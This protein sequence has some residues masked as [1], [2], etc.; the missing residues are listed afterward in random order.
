MYLIGIETTSTALLTPITLQSF[1][2]AVRSNQFADVFESVCKG[3]SRRAEKG[4]GAQ[5]AGDL[6][7]DVGIVPPP[8][9]ERGPT[10]RRKKKESGTARGK[11]GV[12]VNIRPVPPQDSGLS[13]IIYI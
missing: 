11:P 1:F 6:V 10:N 9:I 7:A 13:P 2:C 3:D 4:R 8:T 12:L 5:D